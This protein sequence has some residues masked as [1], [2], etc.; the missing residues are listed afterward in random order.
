MCTLIVGVLLA[1]MAV[2]RLSF[3]V[4]FFSRPALSGFVTASAVRR[5]RKVS[6]AKQK[7]NDAKRHGDTDGYGFCDVLAARC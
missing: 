5:E 6:K 4:R 1:A 2:L 3:L 7:Q